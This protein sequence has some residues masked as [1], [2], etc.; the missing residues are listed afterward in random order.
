MEDLKQIYYNI[1][2]HLYLVGSGVSTEN[3]PLPTTKLK[4]FLIKKI[5]DYFWK[6][7]VGVLQ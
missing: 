2:T 6:M 3:N 5:S 1:I 7:C 4:V